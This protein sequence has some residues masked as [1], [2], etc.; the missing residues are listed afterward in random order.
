ML[1][2]LLGIPVNA[3]DLVLVVAAS[4]ALGVSFLFLVLWLVVCVNRWD[5]R[6]QRLRD[7]EDAGVIHLA[8]RRKK[9]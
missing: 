8:G 7:L 5:R 3:R 6:R 9:R 1:L 4:I 2:D